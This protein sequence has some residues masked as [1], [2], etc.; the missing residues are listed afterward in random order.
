VTMDEEE[1]IRYQ[2][3]FPRGNERTTDR[4]ERDMLERERL[5]ELPRMTTRQQWAEQRGHEPHRSSRQHSMPPPR[6]H[7]HVSPPN[8]VHRPSREYNISPGPVFVQHRTQSVDAGPSQRIRTSMHN[9]S[10]RT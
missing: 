6:Q 7:R 1:V 2:R 5:R 3:R 8:L 10:T 9:V 4:L